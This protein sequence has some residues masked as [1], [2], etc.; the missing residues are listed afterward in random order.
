MKKFFFFR[1]SSSDANN[2][3]SP[4]SSDSIGKSQ[5]RKEVSSPCLRRSLSLSSGSFYDSGKKNFTDPSRSPC[6]SKKVHPKKSGRDSCRGRTRTPERQPPESFFQT[7][8]AENGY[9]VGKHSG[10]SFRT[11]HYDHPSESSSHC[12]S[13][14]SSKV[15]DRY[16]DGE[17]EQ[18]SR[19]LPPRVHLTAPGSPLPDVRK[20]RPISQSF[21]ETKPSKLSFTSGEFGEIGFENESPR[22]L[23]KKVV[24]RLSQSRSLAKISPEDFDSDG[25]ITIEDIYSGN[26]SRCPSVCSDGVPRKS[27]SADDSNGRTYEY[28]H[29]EIP[30]F[31]ERK[32]LGTEDDSDSVLLRK[33]KEAEERAV[34]LSEELEDRNFLHGR[35]LS[36][37]VLIQTIR[38]LT[39]EK[40]QMAFEVTSML[41]NQV[42]ERASAKEE[43]RL[44]QAELDSRTRRLETEKNELQS[45]LEQ[46]LDRRS[47]E[48]SL[49]LEKYQI[50]EH[51]LRERVREL[52]EQNV[53]LQREVSSFN[54][55]E[56]D[57]RS[58]IS[59]SEKE[60][61][62]LSKRIDE[63]SEENQNLRQQLSQLHEDYRVAQDDREYVRENY[64]EKVKECEDLHRSIARL[65]RTCNEQEK[66]IDSL[67]GFCEG[68][69]KKSPANYDNQLEKSQV[70]QIRLVGVERAL[71]K[72]VESCRI[73]IDSLC[74]ENISLLN[75]LRGSGKEGGFST[76][77]LDQELCNRVCCLQNQGLNLLRESSQ[78][79]GKLLEYTKENVRQNGGID[80]QFLIE[81]NVKMQ[82]L[83]RGIETLTGSLQTVSTVISEKSYPV[84]SDSQ[85]PDEIKQS[86]LKSETLLTTMLR[87]KLYSKEMDIEQLQADLAAAVRGNDI[88]KCELQNALDTLSCAKHKLKD[89]ELQTI[90]KDENIN[91]LQN[92]LQECMKELTVVKGILPK[93]SQERDF[94]WEEVKNYNE[95]NMLLNSE[96]NM[97]KKKVE[98]LDEDILMK[99]GQITILKDSIGKPFDLLASPDS[100]R[101]F[102]LE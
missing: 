80:G 18:E 24:E 53:S 44:L 31:G 95:K 22:K 50:E 77:K 79:C 6:H 101:E 35:G 71:R 89:L 51:R 73:E 14:V 10:A 98:T 16:I 21:R 19:Q 7:C 29:E 68:V 82:G 92:D 99:E 76:F 20:Q 48:W 36:V 3:R 100:T 75:R 49:K 25:P 43:A 17:Q 55:K 15:L 84:N 83:K 74:H 87:E 63:V 5:S 12:S 34:L 2:N 86:E 52:A 11:H 91:Q 60:L 97:L 96:I 88:L 94:M 23:A 42:A 56:V 102:L 69:G 66:T 59:S 30:G 62:D 46:E 65:Q 1:T 38:R 58:K 61:E 28:H 64:Q 47:S 90:K 57:N 33:L 78:L 37:P 54:E 4:P 45:A 72:E 9:L 70:E 26:L 85:K 67:R 40:V 13:N 41:R 39:E 81:C 27:C 32:Y 8:D 93:V